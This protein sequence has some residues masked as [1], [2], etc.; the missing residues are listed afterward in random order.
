MTATLT[1]LTRCVA[2]TPGAGTDSPNFVTGPDTN[3]WFGMRAA[4]AS[5]ARRAITHI[6][7]ATVDP[8]FGQVVRTE[9]ANG[10]ST[11]VDYDR[12]GRFDLIARSWGNAPAENATFKDRLKLAAQKAGSSP[13][14]GD[15]RL[16]ALADYGNVR[17]TEEPPKVV[18]G[19]LRSN[20]RRFEPSDSYS[21]LLTAGKTMRET[22]MFADGLGRPV[23]SIGDADVCLGV[24]DGL[25]EGVANESFTADLVQ[26]CKST[27]TG[28]VTPAPKFDALG[29]DLQTFESFSLPTSVTANSGSDL[30]LLQPIGAP[31]D[32]KLQPVASTTF[33]GAGRPLLVE[34]RLS[35]KRYVAGTSQSLYR[36]VPESGDRLARFEALTLSPRCTASSSGRML[37]D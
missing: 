17:D 25:I 30:R 24:H 4:P 23:Q 1:R 27:S 10:N 2:D 26:R 7:R 5:T 14:P 13:P 19:L 16:L 22:A 20:V 3:C 35:E 36:V 15:W 12:W 9:D 34:S 28:V 32:E 11:L 18:P 33:D 21:G 6:S 31:T 29:R 37:G 8:H